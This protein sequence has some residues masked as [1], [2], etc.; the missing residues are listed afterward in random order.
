MGLRDQAQ[1]ARA[2]L[3]PDIAMQ[4]PSR[5]LRLSVSRPQDAEPAGFNRIQP[6][7]AFATFQPIF[8][9]PEKSEVAVSHPLEQRAGLAEFG[10]IDARAHRAQILRGSSGGS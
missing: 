1:I 5:A 10:R 3:S 7:A 4:H 6:L 9:K 8:A 2:A